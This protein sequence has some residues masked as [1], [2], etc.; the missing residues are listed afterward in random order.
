MNA[1][2][3][4]LAMLLACGVLFALWYFLLLKK[5]SCK[6]TQVCCGS[7]ACCKSSLLSHCPAPAFSGTAVRSWTGRDFIPYSGKGWSFFDAQDPTLGLVQ[8]IAGNPN[9]NDKTSTFFGSTDD[10]LKMQLVNAPGIALYSTRLTSSDTFDYGLFLMDV[11]QI[12]FGRFVWPSWWLN[13]LIYGNDPDKWSINGEIDI[14]EGGWQVGGGE[15]A[16]NTF[17]VHTNSRTSVPYT[18]PQLNLNEATG[19]CEY[20][21]PSNGKTCGLNGTQSCPF[22]G[23]SRLW[24]VSAN[25]YGRSFQSNGG[26]IYAINVQC[27]SS[28]KLWFIPANKGSSASYVKI[29]GIMTSRGAL[30]LETLDALPT[31]DG[32][33]TLNLPQKTPTQVFSNLQIVIDTDVCGQA[34]G[35]PGRDTCDPDTLY[36]KLLPVPSFIE[37]S[38]WIINGISVYQ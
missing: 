16:L 33:E 1:G 3:A 29:R 5:S 36:N 23:C 11:R 10:Q 22:L 17:S 25:G 4:A 13:G 32:V 37:N 38:A 12:P 30:K 9:V 28:L 26:G 2:A 18:Q 24:P 27:D 34:F 15:N 7:G 31:A 8:Y 21:G 19:N 35:S 6:G 14:I 20:A